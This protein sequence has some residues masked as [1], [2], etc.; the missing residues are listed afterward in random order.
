GGADAV[1]ARDR[2]HDEDVPPREQRIGRRVAHAI[3]LF[4]DERVLLDVRVGR[5]DVGLGLVVV[6]V[7]DEVV[8][9]VVGEQGL[10]LAVEL[11]RQRLVV[12]DD[13]RRALDLLDDV[14][15]REG[16]AAAGDAQQHLGRIAA[17][18]GRDQLLD[19]ARLVAHRR[20]LGLEAERRRQ[21]D[22]V[23]DMVGLVRGY[24]AILD[25]VDRP[26]GAGVD[27]GPAGPVAD[28]EQR[29]ARLLAARPCYL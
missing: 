22:I 23:Y 9:G 29:A 11:V 25:L 17:P 8:D 6:V 13:Q 27:A 21:G 7:A 18:G 4:V 26:G 20:E 2:R 10:E 16:L 5:G 3:D 12:G 19:R 15:D 24:Y 14:G 28:V 1:D